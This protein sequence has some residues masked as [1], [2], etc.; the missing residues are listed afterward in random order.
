VFP[1]PFRPLVR[2][3][4]LRPFV[5]GL[6]LEVLFWRAG[7]AL[8]GYGITAGSWRRRLLAVPYYA[9]GAL[10]TV[11][12]LGR[13]RALR[14]DLLLVARKSAIPAALPVR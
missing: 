2:D 10:G 4:A 7:D 6:G 11:L 3:A 14:S 5:E 1:T 9:L 13:W 8:R 12:S